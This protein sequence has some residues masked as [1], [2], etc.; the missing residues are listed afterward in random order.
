MSEVTLASFRSRAGI[1]SHDSRQVQETRAVPPRTRDGFPAG[2][3]AVRVLQVNLDDGASS[4]ATRLPMRLSSFRTG[5]AFQAWYPGTHPRPVQY[6]LVSKW[7]QTYYVQVWIG[8]KTSTGQ[9]AL[10]ARMIASISV[11]RPRTAP[12]G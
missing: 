8:P 3:I 12:A 2:G 4:G 5:G 6:L 10:L 11:R 7:H 9:R 1:Q